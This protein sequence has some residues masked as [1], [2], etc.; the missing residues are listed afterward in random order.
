MKD[1]L[2]R[3]A[4]GGIILSM[5]VGVVYVWT[6]I[7]AALSLGAVHYMTPIGI[8]I[9]TYVAYMIGDIAMFAYNS[10]KED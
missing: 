9:V 5:V 2:T 1:R 10:R 8:A 7:H 4:I 3:I 6:L